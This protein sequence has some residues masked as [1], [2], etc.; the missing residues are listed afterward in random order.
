M[1]VHDALQSRR[2]IQRFRTDPVSDDVIDRALAAANT[3][4]NHK[5]TWPWRFV[6][7]GPE[8][9][10]LLFRVGLR[11]KE[12]KKGPSPELAQ[13]VRADLMNPDRLIVVSQVLAGDPGRIEEDHAA[14]ACAVYALM[15][16]LHADGVGTKWGTGGM[17][18]DPE[19]LRILG[20]GATEKII[21]L[22]WVGHP[23]IVPTPPKR[24]PLSELVRRVP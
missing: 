21:A 11:L 24:L 1:N 14:C 2:T 6:L 13:H 10:E 17:T 12:A 23:A 18:R 15:L 20:I 3:A 9:R 8:A 7:P 22:V 16:S 19:A 5:T 4:P